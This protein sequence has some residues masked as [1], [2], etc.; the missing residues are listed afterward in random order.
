MSKVNGKYP[1]IWCNDCNDYT[2]HREKLSAVMSGH[3]VCN[4][5]SRMNPVCELTKDGE[6]HFSKI[7][8]GVLWIEFNEDKTFK[9]KHNEPAIG[10][11][12]LMS[13][14]NYSFTWQTTLIT[15][16]LEVNNDNPRKYIKFKTENTTYK[17][18]YHIL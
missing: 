9:E 7:S 14:F 1:I 12:L 15:E 10:R 5:C 13:P 11:S 3:R 6:E 18:Y 4:R 16:I 17:L 8:N 2:F